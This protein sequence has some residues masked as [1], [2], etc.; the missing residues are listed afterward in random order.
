MLRPIL[1]LA[2]IAAAPALADP[3]PTLTGGPPIVIA[4]RGASGYLPEHTLAAY[5]LGAVMGADYIEPDLVLTADGVAIALHDLSLA[6]TTNVEDLFAP[7]NGG[8]D[9][10]EFT[11]AEIKTL[12]VEPQGTAGTRHPGFAP[13]RPDPF[14]VPT[15]RE[16]I[17]FLN[18]YNAGNGTEIGI[19][20]EVKA[21][22]PVLNALVVEQLR[23]GSFGE[24]GGDAFIQ[25]F[26]LAAL[27][28]IREVQSALG[29]DIAQVALG[30]GLE[31]DGTFG[32]A[33]PPFEAPF[34]ILP[35]A[36]IAGFADGVGISRG[37]P[38]L[39][40]GFV[41]AAH[42]L[43]LLVHPYTFAE[44]D[45]EAARAELEAALALGIDGFFTNYPDVAVA[46]LAGQPPAAIPLPA[47]A[48]LLLAGLAGLARR[49][50]G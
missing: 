1:A 16:V 24:A 28:D 35:L 25:S 44:P 9:A 38:A 3:V 22:S 10:A 40:E 45:P 43:G 26:D 15:F 18:D 8:F 39:G 11:L 2:A 34:S 31:V 5:E 29:T 12:T 6:R 13:S 20:P 27:R 42:G 50:R 49:R 36:E 17:D 19:Y 14:A 41:E 33:V 37:S 21:P 23:A 46:I 47:T 7:R 48:W 4:H 30:F 32:L